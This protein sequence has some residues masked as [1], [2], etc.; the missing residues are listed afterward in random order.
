MVKQT[1]SKLLILTTSILIT[2]ISIQSVN[3]NPLINYGQVNCD[4][5]DNG[6]GGF[7]PPRR[8]KPE[9]LGL[10]IR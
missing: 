10:Y 8:G 5:E 9:G 7:E 2:L 3:A 4:S 6:G 1:L